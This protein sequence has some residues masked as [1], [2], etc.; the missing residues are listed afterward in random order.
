MEI[1]GYFWKNEFSVVRIF[2]YVRTTLNILWKSDVDYH[3]DP[4]G[5]THTII[6]NPVRTDTAVVVAKAMPNPCPSVFFRIAD[7]ENTAGVIIK[8]LCAHSADAVQR[9]L[10]GGPLNPSGVPWH[11]PGPLQPRPQGVCPDLL[12]PYGFLILKILLTNQG[13]TARCVA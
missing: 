10:V 6:K 12:L 3:G 11:T 4:R 1:V 7:V 5:K 9:K 2:I 13:V 8:L